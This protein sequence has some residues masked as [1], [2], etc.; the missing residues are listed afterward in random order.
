MKNESNKRN[1]HGVKY[2]CDQYRNIGGIRFVNWMPCNVAG[3][4]E[5]AKAQGLKTRVINGDLYVQE[6]ISVTK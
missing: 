6:S 2:S 1:E 3:E 4:R 5:K